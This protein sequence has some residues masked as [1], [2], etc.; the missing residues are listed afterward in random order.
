MAEHDVDVVVI[1]AGAAGLVATVRLAQAGLRV[2]L[3][4]ARD[5]LGGRILSAPAPGWPIPVEL[6][7]EFV[8]GTNDAFDRWLRRGKLKR[9]AVP[10]QHWWIG[11]GGRRSLP[12]AWERI[13]A[14]M[15]RI[16]PR[17]RRSFGEWLEEH[18]L[19]PVEDVLTR[20]FVE[21]FHGAPLDRMSAR[22]LYRASQQEDE[23]SRLRGGYG[24]FLTL[25]AAQ[26]KSPRVQL[27]HRT[28]VSLIEWRRGAVTVQAGRQSWRA[29]AA[30]VTVPIGVLQA[31]TSEAIR[32]DPPLKQKQRIWSQ[33]GRGHARRVVLRL[34]ADAWR[35]GALPPELRASEGRAFGFLHSDDPAFPVWWA[36]APRPVLV[37]WCGGPVAEQLVGLPPGRV[38]RLAQ[39]ALARVLACSPREIGRLVVDGRTYDWSADPFARCAYSFSVAGHEDAPAR[40]AQPIRNTLFFAGEATA[41]ALEVGT[42]SGAVATGERAAAEIMEAVA[43]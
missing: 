22:T 38:L 28:A 34:R 25:L 26:L 21:G 23:Q 16:G 41:D 3:L 8:H 24:R 19:A 6:G 33:I 43:S 42:V 27:R 36:E 20:T 2:A 4:E 1:G 17:F 35:R 7:A 18:R 39:T 12:D 31:R 5:R 14:V 30:L 29:R 13:Q 15:A 40:L 37:G 9:D 11:E 10:E 32:F